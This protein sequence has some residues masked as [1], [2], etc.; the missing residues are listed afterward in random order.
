M[1]GERTFVIVKQNVMQIISFEAVWN[2]GLKRSDNYTFIFNGTIRRSIKKIKR[3]NT[4]KKKR[5]KDRN[6]VNIELIANSFFLFFRT[7]KW[8]VNDRSY[9]FYAFNNTL[10][11][12]EENAKSI[13]STELYWWLIIV[14]RKKKN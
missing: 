12:D 1:R 2:Y 4:C 3:W 6:V 13:Y 9:A 14:W 11:F 8:K 7:S 10:N 5:G